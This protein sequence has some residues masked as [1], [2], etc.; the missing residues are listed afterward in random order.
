MKATDQKEAFIPYKFK[1]LKVYTSTEWLAGNK[2]KYRQVF[3]QSEVSF[4]YCELSLANKL[5]DE[6]DWMADIHLKCFNA[7]GNTLICDLHYNKKVNKYDQILFVREGWGNKTRNSFWKRGTYYWEAWIGDKKVATK[8]FYIEATDRQGAEDEQKSLHDQYA[9]VKSIRLFEGPYDDQPEEDRTYLKTFDKNETRYVYCDI[10]LM[11][12]N[13]KRKWHCEMFIKFYNS[14][15]ELKGQVVKLL[16]VQ[17]GETDIQITAGWGANRPGSWREGKYT[18]EFVFMDELIAVVPFDV[19]SKVQ[20]GESQMLLPGWP[21]FLLPYSEQMETEF[22]D[23]QKKLD[24]LIGLDEIKKQ[25]NDH[26]LYIKFLRLRRNKGIKDKRGINIHSVFVGNPGTGKTTVAKMM[27]KLYHKMGLLTRGHV[28]EVDRVDLVG[29]YIG[30]TAPKVKEAIDSARGGVLFIDEAYALARK[31]DDSKDF[32]KEVIEI[33]LKEMS[34]GPGDL[35]VIVAGYPEEMEYFLDSNPGLKSRFKHVFEFRDYLPEELMDIASYLAE[36]EKVKLS[37]GAKKALQNMIIHAFRQRDKSFGNARFVNDLIEKAKINLGLRVMHVD[38]PEKLTKRELQTILKEDVLNI[39]PDFSR[40]KLN[41]PIDDAELQL[42]LSDLHGLYG[43]QSVK[44]SVQEMVDLVKYHLRQGHDVLNHFN[45]HT[46]FIGNPGTGKTTVARILARIYKAL[47]IL[48]R[49]HLIETD[50]QGM[51]AG[52]VG[53]TAIKTDK[54]INEAIGGVLFIDE[55]YAL[56][57]PAQ[58]MSNDFGTEVIQVLIKRMEDRKSE[59]FLFAA[60]YPDNMEIFLNSNPGFKSRFDH[61]LYFEDYNVSE[62]SGIFQSMIRKDGYKIDK[63]ALEELETQIKDMY[64]RRDKYFGNARRMRILADQVI[65]NQNLRASK[66]S[67]NVTKTIQI[68][69][70]IESKKTPGEWKA[71]KKSIGFQSGLRSQD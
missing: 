15:R 18:A 17:G 47:G 10:E 21:N 58:S 28:H 23:W 67:D 8:Y 33:L 5:Y 46:L 6:S 31:N 54:K 68:E 51:V 22:I 52:Y 16:R 19:A 26:S 14:A 7:K 59:F 30:Q 2:K 9:T 70:I 12:N 25:I 20:L 42:A 49:G 48:E 29:E 63:R 37:P 50:R 44:D 61:L 39:K 45:M 41:L 27:G 4:I 1:A 40:P 53:Q 11:N 34:N 24:E 65:R 3:D 57:Q 71:P 60:G 62:L 69:D 64:S 55:A 13:Q 38:Q 35:A 43:L 66:A 56:S 36:R 32:G